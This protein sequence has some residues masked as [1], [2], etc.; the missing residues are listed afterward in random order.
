[1]YTFVGIIGGIILGNIISGVCG[2]NKR[3]G[4]GPSSGDFLLMASILVGG[5]IGFGVDISSFA[6][7]NH[8]INKMFQ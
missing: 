2:M 1:M 3:S 6:N 4:F 5:G 7:G 8:F